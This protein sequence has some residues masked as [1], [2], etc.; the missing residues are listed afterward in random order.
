MPVKPGVKMAYEQGLRSTWRAWV[1]VDRNHKKEG[2]PGWAM[3][4]PMFVSPLR[5]RAIKA[6]TARAKRVEDPVTEEGMK[7][8]KFITIDKGGR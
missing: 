3:L 1:I 6:A 8:G 4:W 5:S 2:K 7:Y